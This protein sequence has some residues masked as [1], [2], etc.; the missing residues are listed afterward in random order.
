M[1]S[2]ATPFVAV[3]IG[4]SRTK[5]GLFAQSAAAMEPDRLP[6]VTRMAE[7]P[8][9]GWKSQAGDWLAALPETACRWGIATVVR[10]ADAE[11]RD[12]ILAQR[13]QDTVWLV[14][15]GE[16]PLTVDLPHPER[17][18]IDRLLAGLAVDTLRDP[19]NAAIAVDLGSA[20]TIDLVTADGTFRGGA[21]LP[22]IG[23]SARA[24]NEQTDQLP[25]DAMR[26]LEAPPPALG[27][28]TTAAIQSG[29]YWGAVGAIR[30]L[31]A[32]LAQPLAQPVDVFLTGGASPGVAELLGQRVRHVPALVL[33]GIALADQRRAGG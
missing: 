25:L 17:V 22:G 5:L 13:P 21:I 32:R 4:N 12:F 9:V 11:L 6:L 29:L 15:A 2:A 24:L 20:I 30:E 26:R 27:T 7:L 18:G 28:S 3:D 23:M 10:Q 33:A 8:G 31:V 19:G 1:T 16:L 14:T